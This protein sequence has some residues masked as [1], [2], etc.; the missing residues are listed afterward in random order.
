LASYETNLRDVPVTCLEL[1]NGGL[2]IPFLQGIH[3]ELSESLSS[4][5]ILALEHVLAQGNQMNLNVGI[6]LPISSCVEMIELTI[7]RNSSNICIP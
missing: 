6:V 5:D 3:Y 7:F 2:K 1:M 4:H